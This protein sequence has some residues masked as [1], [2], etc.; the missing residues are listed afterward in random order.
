MMLTWAGGGGGLERW[1]E[2][3]RGRG[4]V[5]NVG[6]SWPV[7]GE[8]GG[9]APSSRFDVEPSLLRSGAMAPRG[10]YRPQMILGDG[11]QCANTDT[12]PSADDAFAPVPLSI[13]WT[14]SRKDLIPRLFEKTKQN[15]TSSLVSSAGNNMVLFSPY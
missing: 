12:E 11:P 9:R 5:I 15:V 14:A 3:Y 10:A 2:Q 6:K 4:G 7:E 8:R 1:R 13:R